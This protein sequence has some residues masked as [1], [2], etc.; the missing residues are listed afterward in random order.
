MRA[1]DKSGLS[2]R[3]NVLGVIIIAMSILLTG[4]T[5][6]IFFRRKLLP[7][8]WRRRRR[9]IK[10]KAG[11]S[12]K[13][14]KMLLR[15][16]Q[17]EEL[18][19]A[20]DNFSEECLV[21]SGAFGNVYRGTFHDEGTLAT[22]KPHADSYQ[23]FEEFRNGNLGS[24]QVRLLSKVKH[25]NL[26][27][28]VGFCE[29]PGASGAKILVYE[30]VPNGSLLEHIIGRRGRVLTWRQRVNL[31][32]GA[33]KGIAHLHEEVKPSVIHRDLKPSNILIGEGFEAKVSDF[34]LVKS[35][36]VE[37]QS[38]VSSQIKGTPGYLDPAYCSSFHLTPFS[39][40]YSFGVILLQLVAARPVVDTGRNNSRYHIMDWARPSLERED[41]T[42]ILDANLLSQPCNMEVMLKM[43][44]LALKCVVKSPKQRPTMTQVWQELEEA[45]RLA[46]GNSPKPAAGG[47]P[48]KSRDCYASQSFS[49]DGVGYQRFHVEMD[50]LSFQSASLRCLDANNLSIDI[51]KAV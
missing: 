50:S 8:V 29:E 3:V 49:I 32:I 19:R 26:V 41:V 45:I 35:G 47:G 30:Y 23:S 9:L 13:D 31:A 24:R 12:L 46:D 16:F 27:N 40:V 1:Q 36:P 4:V 51:D 25:R 34:G 48:R 39:D 14:E 18:M 11:S 20:I 6:C 43:G 38:H 44:Q 10:G 21:G 28:L 17:L 7:A 5:F 15:R 37:D 33:A 42:G 2:S 22:K